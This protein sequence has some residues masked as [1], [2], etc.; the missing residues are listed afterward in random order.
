MSEINQPIVEE[1]ETS[2][3]KITIQYSHTN[4]SNHENYSSKESQAEVNKDAMVVDKE[5]HV[6]NDSEGGSP[7]V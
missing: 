6:G 3:L 7:D 1:R 2:P 4:G 5:V